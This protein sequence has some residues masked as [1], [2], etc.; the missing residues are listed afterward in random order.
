MVS[1]DFGRRTIRGLPPGASS[2]L[3]GGGSLEAA[4]VHR[5]IADVW[6]SVLA[7][8]VH[9]PLPAMSAAEVRQHLRRGVLSDARPADS[10]LFGGRVRFGLD[11]AG[12]F[13]PAGP[14]DEMPD[15]ARRSVSTRD[16]EEHYTG[17]QWKD[18]AEAMATTAAAG[19]TPDEFKKAYDYYDCR[20]IA[21]YGVPFGYPNACTR[22]GIPTSAWSQPCGLSQWTG[23][24]RPGD[25]CP[26]PLWS[27][28]TASDPFET[29]VAESYPGCARS[30][31][32]FLNAAVGHLID[33]ADLVDWVLCQVYGPG[34]RCLQVALGNLD[35]RVTC[36]D[37]FSDAGATTNPFLVVLDEEGATMQFLLSQFNSGDAERRLCAVQHL[38]LLVFHELQHLCLLGGLAGV[39]RSCGDDPFPFCHEDG[40]CEPIWMASNTLKAL[41]RLRFPS[42]RKSPC[43]D[44]C[45]SD[46]FFSN[47]A[48]AWGWSSCLTSTALAE[49]GE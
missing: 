6:R 41:L 48:D 42:S 37:P 23:W 4:G 11:G 24:F 39:D 20:D 46:L 3:R 19:C 26:P 1:H 10:A 18:Y 15:G 47:N 49:Q 45:L 25:E 36:G 43:C 38:S 40:D 13:G 16:G 34:G 29:V 22:M 33:N 5:S 14:G 31:T 17:H 28:T 27:Q 44:G 8:P 30:L 12:Q 32:S 35:G 7:P 2:A 9:T 21:K